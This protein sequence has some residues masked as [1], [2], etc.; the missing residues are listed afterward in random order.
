[1]V[2]SALLIHIN[3]RV[4][5]IGDLLSIARAE[6]QKKHGLKHA[7][8]KIEELVYVPRL[9]VYVVLYKAPDVRGRRF[10]ATS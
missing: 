6:A 10:K 5:D 4:K 9:K 7:R 3:K 8:I 2:L 1:M